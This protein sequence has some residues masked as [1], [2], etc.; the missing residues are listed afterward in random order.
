MAQRVGATGDLWADMLGIKK[1]LVR[2]I[3]RL[4]KLQASG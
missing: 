3:A 4:R 1:S 2:P